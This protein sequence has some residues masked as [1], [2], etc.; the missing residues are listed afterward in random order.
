GVI[1]LAAAREGCVQFGVD[2]AGL[3]RLDREL[4]KALCIHFAGRP[5]GLTTLAVAVGEEPETIEDVYEPYLLQRGLIA[6]TPRGRVAMDG[7]YA[8]LDLPL[9]AT[10][11]ARTATAIDPAASRLF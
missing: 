2:D 1:S 8:H 5:V 10:H 4:L 11:G 3:D 6:R 9:P 7:A